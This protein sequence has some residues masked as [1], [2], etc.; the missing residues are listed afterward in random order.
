MQMTLNRTIATWLDKART[1]SVSISCCS[2]PVLILHILTEVKNNHPYIMETVISKLKD[3][4]SDNNSKHGER[5][6]SS[7]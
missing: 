5:S 3:K 4:A 1:V 6:N 2:R 7:S